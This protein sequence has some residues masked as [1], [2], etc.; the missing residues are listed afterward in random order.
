MIAEAGHYALVLALALALIQSTVP[1]MGARWRDP[2][3]MNVA[4][5]TALAQLLF[6]GA[7]FA[8]LVTLHVT[9]DFSVVNVFENSHSLKPLIYKITGVWGNHEGSM[10]LWVSILALFGGLVAGF[11]NNLPLSLR[12]HVLAVQ[13]WIASAFYLFI[14]ITSNPFLRI[15]NPPIEG[16]D[17]NP[18]LQDIGLAVHPPMLYLGYVGF[19]I[20][21]SFAVA[22]LLEGRID[23]AWARWVRPWTLVAWIF[24]TL[25]IAMGSYWAYYELGWGGWWFWDPVEN[26]SLMPWLA[27]TALLHSAV[28]MEK[29]NALKVWTILLSILTFSLSLL[30]TFLVRSGV[31]TSVHAF[32]NDPKRGVFILL[33]LCIFIGGSLT[34]YAFRA[35]SLKQGGL[36][37]PISREGALVL[38]NLLLTCGCATVFL[39]TLYPLFLDAVGGPKLSVGFPFFN[40]TF[41]PMMVPMIIAVGIGP[42]LAWKRGDIL[43]ALQ[44]LWVAYIAT[45]LVVLVAFYVTYGGPV[46]AVLGFGLAA[47]L[48]AAVL[49]EFAERTRLFRLPFPESLRRAIHLPRSAYGM[50]FAHFGLAVSVA[51]FA[52]SAFDKEA[53]QILKPGGTI[54]IAGYELTLQDVTRIPGPNYVADDASIRV[55]R[56]GEL[57]KV[58]HPQRRF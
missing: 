44:R 43:G 26:A 37:A 15:A 5:S 16:R 54:A 11:G 7:S 18:V 41:A 31:L 17:L 32:A 57:V 21:F 36:F 58:M 40:R 55:T 27:G 29:R 3:L 4:R 12:A 50:T 1:I 47:W 33:I 22:A 34:L 56:G 19:S 9:S 20:S 24:L 35:S 48:A 52:A 30:G 14:L 53:I 38:N 45:A 23:A 46:L 42:M 10:L 2:A 6:V 51:G 13:A 8:A 28:V 39:G 49:T 25:G